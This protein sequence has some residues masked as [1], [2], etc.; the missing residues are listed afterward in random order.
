VVPRGLVDDRRRRLVDKNRDDFLVG[1]RPRISASAIPFVRRQ[2]VTVL[3]P[4]TI[5]SQ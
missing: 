3:L 2:R 4:P 1:T 5:D